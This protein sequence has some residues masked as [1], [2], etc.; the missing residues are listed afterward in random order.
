LGAGGDPQHDVLASGAGSQRA[1]TLAAVLGAE[2][3]P[4]TKVDQGVQTSR[5]LGPNGAAVAAVGTAFGQIPLRGG[6]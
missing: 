2:M 1:F 3:L 4:E 5:A 6:N